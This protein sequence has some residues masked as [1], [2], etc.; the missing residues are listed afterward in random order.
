MFIPE[1]LTHHPVYWKSFLFYA[2]TYATTRRIW[3]NVYDNIRV[4]QVTTLQSS[5]SCKCLFLNFKDKPNPKPFRNL[6][7][8]LRSHSRRPR[9]FIR[10]F[11]QP[12]QNEPLIKTFTAQQ[13]VLNLSGHRF[14]YEGQFRVS[15]MIS[16]RLRQRWKQKS[17]SGEDN[18]MRGLG[19]GKV[20]KAGWD[21]GQPTLHNRSR[22]W[23]WARR[24]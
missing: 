1:L 20:Y 7:R 11:D 13:R 12:E 23:V 14:W 18:K 2:R 17:P 4:T 21:A 8:L 24:H 22:D 5:N 6:I 19:Q 15:T 9:R 3:L 16:K 10:N